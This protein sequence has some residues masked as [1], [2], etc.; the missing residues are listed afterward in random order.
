MRRMISLG[1]LRKDLAVPGTELH[2]LWGGFSDEPSVKIRATVH[3]LPFIKQHR[4]DELT[5]PVLA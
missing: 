2:V 1:R 3:A 4:R 5:P